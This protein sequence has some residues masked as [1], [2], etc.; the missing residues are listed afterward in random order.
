MQSENFS[1][2]LV[3]FTG[4]TIAAN[5]RGRVP[6]QSLGLAGS[7]N[8][9]AFRAVVTSRPGLSPLSPPVTARH[10]ECMN[11]RSSISAHCYRVVVVTAVLALTAAG[12]GGGGSNSGS[13]PGGG[14]SS[15]GTPA[16]SQGPLSTGSTSAS[17]PSTSPTSAPRSTSSTGPTTA[18]VPSAPL[19][20]P[21]NLPLWP[22]ASL[23]QAREWERSYAA[24]GHQPWHLDA[25]RT[26]LAFTQGYLGFTGIDQVVSTVVTNGRDAHIGVGYATPS[27]PPRTASAAVV[28][29]VRYG[30]DPTAPWEVV[31]TADTTLTLTTPA[32]GAVVRSPLT[33]GGA[34]TGVDE[35][36]RVQIR[37]LAQTAPLAD[38]PGLPAG[39]TATPW[40]V[41]VPYRGTTE[42]FLTVVASTGGHLAP[43]ER[44]AITGARTG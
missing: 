21:V 11:A 9:D 35:S 18:T 33:V 10:R 12:C 1:G 13:R 25:G 37:T 16:A 30:P 2:L 24:G 19:G 17:A 14:T 27:S 43:V 28:H 32:Y 5:H 42:P 3:P 4:K 23:D 44:F 41:L 31:G 29:L 7:R 8:R 6:V 20:S 38:R 15:T 22:F 40:H 34:I 26:A 39:G 36:I